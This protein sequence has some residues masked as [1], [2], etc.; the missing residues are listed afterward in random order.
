MAA[1]RVEITEFAASFIEEQVSNPTIYQKILDYLNI[2]REY[3][4]FGCVYDP[5]Y[6]AA[7]PPFACRYIV[8]SDTPFTLYYTYDLSKNVVTV[9]AVTYTAGDPSKRFLGYF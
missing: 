9:I 4:Q 8:V 3:P 1:C 2:L 6:P 5:Q 7:R